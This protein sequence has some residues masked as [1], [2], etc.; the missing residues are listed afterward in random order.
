MKRHPFH[1]QILDH[2][3]KQKGACKS[4]LNGDMSGFYRHPTNHQEKCLIGIFI[5]KEYYS[6]DLEGKGLSQVN[7]L[8]KS[9]IENTIGRILTKKEINFLSACQNIHDDCITYHGSNL[10]SKFIRDKVNEAAEK[11]LY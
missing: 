9:A 3:R 5:K 10:N 7:G 4:F 11:Y 2:C 8:V 1:Q 6:T